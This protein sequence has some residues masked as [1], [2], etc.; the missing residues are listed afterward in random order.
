MSDGSHTLQARFWT[1]ILI[2]ISQ[3]AHVFTAKSLTLSFDVQI[4]A[5]AYDSAIVKMQR[6]ILRP[7]QG[8][9]RQ[10]LADLRGELPLMPMTK[11]IFF[12]V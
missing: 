7:K 5:E 12:L 3:F 2:G 4:M 10:Q 6:D 1:A 8:A 9:S 11:G